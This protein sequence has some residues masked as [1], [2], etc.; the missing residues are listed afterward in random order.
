[1]ASEGMPTKRVV[2]ENQLAGRYSIQG[3]FHVNFFR[4]ASDGVDTSH[5]DI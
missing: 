3:L 1:M 5:Q 4:R 2:E